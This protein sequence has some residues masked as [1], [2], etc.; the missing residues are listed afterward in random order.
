VIQRSV[1]ISRA[2]HHYP[3]RR[4]IIGVIGSSAIELSQSQQQLPY[5]VGK[6]IAEAN[7]HLL[8]GGGP[9]VMAAASK[10]FCAV[11]SR[12]GLSIG[13]IPHGKPVEMYP[14]SWIELPVYTHL[15]GENPKGE[16]SRNHIN[17]RSSHAIVAFPGGIG[18]LAEVEL[19]VAREVACPIVLCL[20]GQE[21]IGGLGAEALRNFG[22]PVVS[23]LDAIIEFL[24]TA[25]AQVVV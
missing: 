22:V 2:L 16:D 20:R 11:S 12:T 4:K 1:D 23:D 15:R 9:G 6:W 8:T 25:L 17:V 3:Q 24:N 14:N 19:A 18:T 13:V 5:C 7:C 10:G 21:I